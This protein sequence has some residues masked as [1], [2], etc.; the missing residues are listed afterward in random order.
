MRLTTEH[1]ASARRIGQYQFNNTYQYV[2]AREE[3]HLQWLAAALA[4]LSGRP[5]GVAASADRSGS[6]TQVIDADLEQE[7]A[8]VARWKPLVD[9][10]THDRHRKMLD[11]ILGESLE[12]AG[13]FADALAGHTDLLGRSDT[14][15]GQ[16]GRVLSTRWME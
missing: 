14:G 5:E 9:Q 15:A 13:L 10:V 16:R 4:G 12:H 1:Q 3:T 6:E 2:I 8:F 11:V 7:R